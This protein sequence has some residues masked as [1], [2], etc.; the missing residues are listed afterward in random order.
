M[1]TPEHIVPEW[2]FLPFYAI[3]RSFTIDIPLLPGLVFTAKLQGVIAMF[4]S[5]ILLM[6]LPWLDRS[7]VKSC[8]FRPAY[9]W[10]VWLLVIAFIALGY[11]GSQ[12][13]EGPPV[14]VGQIAT[15]Y[16]FLHFLV[17]TPWL[18]RKEDASLVPASI[19]DD[20]CCS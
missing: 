2:Y 18:S 15:V 3:L 19:S 7:E 5:I 8:R 17:L 4:G 16:Y 12:K 9:K 14:I 13:P 10:C 20:K 6:F 11:A 1:Q